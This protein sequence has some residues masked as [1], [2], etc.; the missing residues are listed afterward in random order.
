[1]NTLLNDC[2]CGG[3]NYHTAECR[4]HKVRVRQLE[5]QRIRRW[6]NRKKHVCIYSGCKRKVKPVVIYHQYCN[7]HRKEAREIHR[8]GGKK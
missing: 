7:E 4:N 6:G 8:R 2:I 3:K 1:M 5:Y